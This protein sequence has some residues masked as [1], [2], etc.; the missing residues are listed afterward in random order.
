MARAKKLV[1]K[2]PPQK[3]L[4]AL[5]A[6][7]GIDWSWVVKLI[8]LVGPELAHLLLASHQAKQNM[9]GA[10]P[11]FDV[12]KQIIISFITSSRDQVLSWIEDGESGL[13][14]ALVVL[15]GSKSQGVATLLEQYKGQI[16]AEVDAI[17][18]VVLDQVIAMLKGS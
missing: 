2:A 14:E 16:L 17:D 1:L 18:A 12:V 5:A 9:L 10:M 11:G 15:V 3:Q 6:T 4:K 13:Y 7:L 8:E